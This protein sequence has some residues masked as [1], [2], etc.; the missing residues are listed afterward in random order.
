MVVSSPIPTSTMSTRTKKTKALGIPTI[1]LSLDKPMLSEKIVEALEEYGF[2]KVT[3]HGVSNEIISGMEKEADDFFSKP[4][5]DKQLAGPANPFGY[6][7]KNIGFHG[8]KGDLEYLLLH[9]KPS[10]IFERSKSISPNPSKFRYV[11]NDYV[12]AVRQ[13]AC[14]ILDL[15]AKGLR[16]DDK[17]VFSRLIRDG[18]SDSVFRLNYYPSH[19]KWSPQTKLDHLDCHQRPTNSRIGFGEHSDPQILTIL[20]SND[21]EGLEIC[22]RD[23]LWVPVPPSP[24]EFCV[25]AGDS[26]Q[27]MTN[28][29]IPA[30]RHRVIATI[31]TKPRLSMMYF[32]APPLDAWIAPLPEMSSLIYKPS[33]Y[34]PFTWGEYKR[35]AYSLRLGDSRLE[36]FVN[37]NV[38]D[39]VD[40]F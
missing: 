11:V 10:M 25:I 17:S 12:V 19:K 26:L 24:S 38:K 31:S 37:R 27:A 9:T 5:W 23:G 1:D 15:T 33:L 18:E 8:D 14:D 30:L 20:R 29:R 36:L 7:C 6:G 21:V 3:N 34:K 4:D 39:K 35:A 13:L 28:G 22:S 2:F 16:V 40:A 32:G